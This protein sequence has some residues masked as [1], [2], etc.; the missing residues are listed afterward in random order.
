M[1]PLNT[2]I[3][4]NKANLAVI[5]ESFVANIFPTGPNVI[6]PNKAINTIELNAILPF[7]PRINNPDPFMIGSSFI[8]SS[9]GG[10]PPKLNELSES[11][12]IFTIRI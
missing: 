3:K 10:S 5:A 4:H 2:A 11:M 12:M 9:F 7:A 6:T 1:N 8:Y